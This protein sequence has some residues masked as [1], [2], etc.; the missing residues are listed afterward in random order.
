MNTRAKLR[1]I[2]ELQK[3]KD[4][5]DGYPFQ[6]Y[7]IVSLRKMLDFFADR[8]TAVWRKLS[9]VSTS[10]GLLAYQGVSADP[11]GRPD[12]ETRK[13]LEELKQL[14]QDLEMSSSARNAEKLLKLWARRKENVSNLALKKGIDDLAEQVILEFEN[15]T[16]LAISP[17]RAFYYNQEGT[18][19]GKKVIQKFRA[20]EKEAIEAGRCFALGRYTACAFHMMRIM[21]YIVHRFAEKV[22]V[23]VNPDEDSWG[24]ILDHIWDQKISKWPK[25]P[26]KRKYTACWRSIDGL[27]QRRNEI[28]H[29]NENYTE[30]GA[31]DLIGRVKSCI[32]DYLK[33]PDPPPLR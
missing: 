13:K 17:S 5:R 30:E 15:K 2:F 27:R 9:M 11:I 26:T 28:M 29:H 18:V 10:I 14:F 23:T 4:W 19:L 16:L 7:R 6:P 8:Y 25:S 3:D 20:L 33:L 31:S 1:D 32:E 24:Q 12:K 21:E 22:S